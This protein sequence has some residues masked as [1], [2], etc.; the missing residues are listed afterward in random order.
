M[1]DFSCDKLRR[2]GTG[3]YSRA[4]AK[5]L[6]DNQKTPHVLTSVLRRCPPRPSPHPHNSCPKVQKQHRSAFSGLKQ[7]TRSNTAL[8][9]SRD[10]EPGTERPRPERPRPERPRHREAQAP[11]DMKKSGMPS[12]H[13]FP[14]RAFSSQ[15]TAHGISSR[16]V[17]GCVLKPT[18]CWLLYLATRH[19]HPALHRRQRR[20]YRHQ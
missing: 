7:Q 18:F 15:S 5:G 20:R 2:T 12:A 3:V 4:D 14:Q 8:D 1:P 17:P 13:R 16:G 19:Q 10:S 11:R 6:E 9:T